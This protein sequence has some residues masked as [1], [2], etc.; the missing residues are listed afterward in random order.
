VILVVLGGLSAIVFLL[1]GDPQMLPFLLP[2]VMTLGAA[3]FPTLPF[4]TG[5]SGLLGFDIRAA[6]WLPARP[7]TLWWTSLLTTGVQLGI[8]LTVAIGGTAALTLATPSLSAAET[9]GRILT[10]SPLCLAAV[11]LLRAGLHLGPLMPNWAR[12]ACLSVGAFAA[13][14][15]PVDIGLSRDVLGELRLLV[16]IAFLFGTVMALAALTPRRVR[17]A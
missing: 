12:V 7:R 14:A 1:S 10:S 11:L 2:M 8:A 15:A 3:L 6:L 16:S 9:V 13:L 4:A 17:P 5:P